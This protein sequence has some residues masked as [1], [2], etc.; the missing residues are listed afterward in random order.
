MFG[1]IHQSLIKA[2]EDGSEGEAPRR[3]LQ[4]KFTLRYICIY[5]KFMKKTG[6]LMGNFPVTYIFFFKSYNAVS[7]VTVKLRDLETFFLDFLLCCYSAVKSCLTLCDHMDCSS[8]GFLL[9]HFQSLLKLTPTESAIQPSHPLISLFFCL[10]YFPAS[11]SFPVSQLFISS[12]QS[13]GASASASVLPVNT[14]GWLP[15]GW[16][17][18]PLYCPMGS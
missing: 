10:Q 16:L 6:R 7:L 9:P 13:V 15:L 1:F 18:W 17:V 14:Q 3:H 4:T 11:E 12:G 5:A 8:P 2:E